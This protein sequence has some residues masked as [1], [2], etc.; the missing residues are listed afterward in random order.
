MTVAPTPSLGSGDKLPYEAI[1]GTAGEP[2]MVPA[3]ARNV[4][5]G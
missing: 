4:A 3:K 5:G 1:R 2:F